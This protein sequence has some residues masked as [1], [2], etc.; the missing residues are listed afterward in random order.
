MKTIILAIGAVFFSL[1]SNAFGSYPMRDSSS[2]MSKAYNEVWNAD[3]QRK[4]DENID[5]NRKVGVTLEFV[6]INKS[7][8]VVIEQISHDFIFGS[9]IFLFNQFD[10]D[11]R[12]NAYKNLF[13]N[14]FNAAT[15]PFYWKT[16]EP[17]QGELRF[18]KLSSFSYRRPPTDEIV[19]F[20]EKNGIGMNGHAIIYG[21]RK[22]GHPEWMPDD[23]KQ[24]ELL[25]ES[26]VK[27]LANRYEGRIQR[28]DIVNEPTDQ[29]NRGIMPD[30]YT[31]KTY[32]WAEREFPKSVLFNIN[33]ADIK[34]PI[35]MVRRYAEL[36]R[37]LKDRGARVDITGIQMHIFNP[38]GARLVA[39]G[40]DVLTPQK[41]E[42]VLTILDETELPIHIS[43][44]TI[45]APDT[46]RLGQK[47]QGQI[48]RNLYRY[49]FSHPTVMG[50]TWWNA[51]DGGA[52]EGEPSLSG[53]LDENLNP[54]SV[55]YVLRNLI[56]TEWATNV[57]SSVQNDG[58]ISFRGFKG[59]YLISWTDVKGDV[60]KEEVHISDDS[61]HHEFSINQ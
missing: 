1:C 53:L 54:K 3:V 36:V 48:A 58:K 8:K 43:E 34:W 57:S 60:R 22:W 6:G 33:D 11:T 24:M 30:D 9:N 39:D 31:Y 55:Y 19:E 42:D 25:F 41:N 46:T 17:V 40:G 18:E 21:S 15:I 2:V 59:N 14:I 28:W 32:K 4:I 37:N 7:K 49:W 38:K 35:P 5:R 52:A 13:T 51:V 23:R 47:V 50:I 27:Q 29:A 12:N 45:S 10:T 61:T 16:L 56:N 20:C 44:V 26:H